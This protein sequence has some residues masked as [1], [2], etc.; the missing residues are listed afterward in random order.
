MTFPSDLPG[1]GGSARTDEGTKIAVEPRTIAAV[2]IE[3]RRSGISRFDASANSNPLFSKRQVIAIFCNFQT[4][5][6]VEA[7][8]P[9]ALRGG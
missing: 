5:T 7:E 6:G 2:L 1:R 4:A 3:F 9:R 8:T